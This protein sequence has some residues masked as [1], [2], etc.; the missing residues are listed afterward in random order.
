MGPRH[1]R[2]ELAG[3]SEEGVCDFRVGKDPHTE[4]SPFPQI[5]CLLPSGVIL[6]EKQGL[7]LHGDGAYILFSLL[8]EERLVF[9]L[10]T[11]L[12]ANGDSGSKGRGG[13]QERAKWVLKLGL[14]GHTRRHQLPSY[15]VRYKGE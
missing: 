14:E 8:L 2:E 9:T 13:F 11:W 12:E 3:H 1:F 7:V 5:K 10:R 6:R 15:E 4:G